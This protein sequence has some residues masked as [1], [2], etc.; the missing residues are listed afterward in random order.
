MR[1][2]FRLMR[3]AGRHVG[4]AA[5]VLG[6]MLLMIGVDIAKPFP[7]KLLVDNVLG[8]HPIPHAIT[9]LPGAD[10]HQG[11]LAWVV[12]ATIGLFVFQTALDMTSAAT[13]SCTRSA[14]RCGFTARARPATRSR[15]SRGT[16]TR[17]RRWCW[18]CCCRCSSRS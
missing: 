16:H 11:L 6:S 2:Q 10:S 15:A 14:C 13:C 12:G 3:Y 18:G 4:S 17:P 8:S 1:R 9:L 5:L 7:T